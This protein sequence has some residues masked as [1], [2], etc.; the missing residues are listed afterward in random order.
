[1][2]CPMFHDD[3]RFLSEE[4]LFIPY[5][6]MVTNPKTGRL[7]PGATQIRKEALGCSCNNIGGWV[8]DL[9]YCPARWALRG[10]AT[11]GIVAD[12]TGKYLWSQYLLPQEVVSLPQ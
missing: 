1:M 5:A 2:N 11:S 7:E 10:V 6:P 4:H 9:K 3:C 8:K 12:G